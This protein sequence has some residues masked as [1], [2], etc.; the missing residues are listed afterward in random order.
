MDAQEAGGGGF[1]SMPL[2]GFIFSDSFACAIVFLLQRHLLWML[3]M[4]VWQE[5]LGFCPCTEYARLVTR[6]PAAREFY[7]LLKQSLQE[8]RFCRM[9]PSPALGGLWMAS[10]DVLASH[11]RVLHLGL[12]CIFIFLFL[13]FFYFSRTQAADPC[14]RVW[15]WSIWRKS[16]LCPSCGNWW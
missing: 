16:C 10:R 4:E 9:L 14:R 8:L 2:P 7:F 5:V 6:K 3:P 15:R 11:I 12:C 13:L 1:S